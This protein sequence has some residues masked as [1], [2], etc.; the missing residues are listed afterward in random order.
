MSDKFIKKNIKLSLEFD[1]YL[2]NNPAL[3]MKIPN[4]G[5]LVFTIKGDKSFNQSSRSLA[6]SARTSRSKVVEV[7]KQGSKWEISSPVTA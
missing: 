1:R 6:Q 3:F 4:K 7:Q 2:S 5:L